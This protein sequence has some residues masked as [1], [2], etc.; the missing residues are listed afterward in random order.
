MSLRRLRLLPLL[1]AAGCAA[2]PG[3]PLAD[4]PAAPSLLAEAARHLDAGDEQ[5]ALPFLTQYVEANPEHATI[6]AHLAELLLR[7]KKPSEARSHLE[8]Y[9]VDAQKQG[10]VAAKHLVHS[11]ARLVEIAGQQGDEYAEHL[12]RGM[13]LFLVAEGVLQHDAEDPAA[14]RIFFQAIA[15]LK[16]AAKEKPDEPRPHWYLHECWSHLGQSQPARIHLL[17]ARKLAPLGGL[18]PCE[19]ES[20]ALA[21]E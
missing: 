13:G 17:R 14:Q 15:E 9:V 21:A 20:L 19:A 2:L 4:V 18:T 6:R 10:D 8:Q 16:L 5:A 11:H 7:L 1:L 12:Y 3:R